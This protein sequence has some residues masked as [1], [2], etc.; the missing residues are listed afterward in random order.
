MYLRK[1]FLQLNTEIAAILRNS[2]QGIFSLV[3]YA[4]FDALCVVTNLEP[5]ITPPHICRSS[6]T[7]FCNLEMS[8]AKRIGKGH[9]ANTYR[10]L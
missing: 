6:L 8:K 2:L 1:R 7:S 5:H 10:I 4:P 9:V 3:G